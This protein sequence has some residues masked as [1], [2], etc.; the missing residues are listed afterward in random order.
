MVETLLI[1]VP[2]AVFASVLVSRSFQGGRCE[3]CFRWSPL[4]CPFD[5]YGREY[6]CPECHPRF[7][8]SGRHDPEDLVDVGG[9]HNS[10]GGLPVQP[11]LEAEQAGK[12]L[13]EAC[14]QVSTEADDVDGT[15]DELPRLS[16]SDGGQ[17]ERRPS[18]DVLP[19]AIEV[20]YEP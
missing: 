9:W 2:A 19:P 3:H 6:R 15:R 14:E 12:R 5:H 8:G 17:D 13:R 20:Q 4:L 7:E 10:L 1:L 11:H 18:V 16:G